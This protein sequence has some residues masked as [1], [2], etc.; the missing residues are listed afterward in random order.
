ML[1]RAGLSVI[2]V[3]AMTTAVA[4]ASPAGRWV[5]VEIGGQPVARGVE[6]SFELDGGGRVSGRGGCNRYGG[7][8]RLGADTLAFG[9]LMATEMAC[10][11]PEMDQESRFFQAMAKV[12]T[13]RLDA[14]R[15]VLGDGEG[16][17]VV[18]FAPA[19]PGG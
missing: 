17:P 5:A 8:A 3:L 18:V 14:G 4:A 19:R 6:T 9:P 15:L 11:R 10:P 2:T 7:A 1:R 13:W 16:R 12:A